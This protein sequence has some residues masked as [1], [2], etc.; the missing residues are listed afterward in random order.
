M[1]TI[2]TSRTKN[3]KKAKKAPSSPPRGG[4]VANVSDGIGR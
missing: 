1:R 2:E 4:L 3:S